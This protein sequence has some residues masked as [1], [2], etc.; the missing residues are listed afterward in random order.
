MNGV[1]TEDILSL[2]K[3]VML[4]MANWILLR[5]PV[6]TVCF[7]LLVPGKHG[8]KVQAPICQMV[9]GVYGQI[10]LLRVLMQPIMCIGIWLRSQVV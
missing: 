8:W 4:L 9:S 5:F 10:S 3:S 6:S 2:I 1:L 7:D